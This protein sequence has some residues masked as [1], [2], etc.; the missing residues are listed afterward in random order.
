MAELAQA[1]RQVNE[2]EIDANEAALAQ[3]FP[4]PPELSP[5]AR[6]HLTPFLQF[7]EAQRIRSLPARP[8]SVASFEQW[9][10]DL[11]VPQAKISATLSAI[12]AL[13]N[14]AALGNP[15]ATPLVRTI[16]A[17][18]T[19]EA[20]RSWTKDEQR[21]F[22]ELPVEVQL[23]VARRERDR[24]I[25]LRRSQNEAA[26]LRKQLRLNGTDSKP[27][28]EKEP[29][30]MVAKN[31]KSWNGPQGSKDMEKDPLRKDSSGLGYPKP[32]S[33]LNRVEPASRQDDG[34]SGKLP[35]ND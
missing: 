20:P 33:I 22:R 12:E 9:Q 4:P 25:T 21:L 30:T 1:I 15:I 3:C 35:N 32:V 27:V 11:G 28:T 16:T 10:K 2:R 5:E 26:E 8:A 14:A 24:E 31:D 6:Q 23:V 29:T 7:C 19:I 17:A 34:F 13:H 18:S